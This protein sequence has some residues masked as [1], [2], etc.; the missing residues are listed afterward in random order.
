MYQNQCRSISVRSVSESVG[1]SF[2]SIIQVIIRSISES[3]SE[4]V[5]ESISESVRISKRVNF[6]S[7][8]V[9]K[10]H[11]LWY[12]FAYWFEID[13]DTDSD[14]WF[15]D[16]FRCELRG[17][18]LILIQVTFYPLTQILIR[19]LIQFWLR[20]DSL[21]IRSWL[22]YSLTDSDTGFVTR[23]LIQR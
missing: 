16:W 3:V 19:L 20:G 14:T 17:V 1:R 15:R 8:T 6:D 4:S 10:Y 2:R 23:S 5:S 18:I 12:G 13:S 21:L 9:Q 7:L 22:K 11:W